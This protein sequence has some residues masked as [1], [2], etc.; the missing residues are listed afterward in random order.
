MTELTKGKT[1]VVIAHRLSTIMD[2]DQI[3]VVENGNIVAK[4]KQQELLDTC[5][6][7]ADMWKAHIDAKDQT[8]E[9]EQA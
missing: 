1:L 3:V 9:E 8:G 6:L 7:Y 2:A 5:P 4:G